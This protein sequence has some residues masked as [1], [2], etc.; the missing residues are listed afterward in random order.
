MDWSER[1]HYVNIAGEKY[2]VI[3]DFADYENAAKLIADINSRVLQF[4]E[5]LKRKY[6]A[7]RYDGGDHGLGEHTTGIVD[8]VLSN[9]NPE[10]IRETNPITSKD[11]SYTIDKGRQLFVCMRE[12]KSPYRLHKRDDLLFVVLHEISHMGAKNFGHGPEFWQVFKFILHEARLSGI[13]NPVNYR[14]YPIDYC[15]LHVDYN[16]YFD[17]KVYSIW[18]PG[19]GISGSESFVGGPADQNYVPSESTHVSCRR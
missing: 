15:G 3:D 18:L 10:V 17:K 11:T 6:G 9:Y 7:N 1:R 19:G 13:Y 2:A 14:E 4:L 8:R 16:P 12:K 5:Y